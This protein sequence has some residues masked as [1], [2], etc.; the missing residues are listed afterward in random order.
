MTVETMLAGYTWEGGLSLPIS[1]AQKKHSGGF[2]SQSCSSAAELA[3]RI[4]QSG[5]GQDEKQRASF[6][7]ALALH[8]N[9]TP[10]LPGGTNTL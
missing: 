1:Q 7:T 9:P 5:P 2:V 4:L 6:S 3:G 10:L 8:R